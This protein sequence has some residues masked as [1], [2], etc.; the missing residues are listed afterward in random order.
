MKIIRRYLNDILLIKSKKKNDLRGSFLKIF[1]KKI[2]KSKNINFEIKDCFISN[3]KKNVIRGMHYDVLK[4]NNNK[5][6]ICTKGEVLDVILDIRKNSNTYGKFCKIK[7]NE[8]DDKMIFI[9]SG[10]AH[11]FQSL[12]NGSELLYFSSKDYV[13][14]DE[15][16]F[17]WNSFGFNWPIKKPILSKRDTLHPK[18]I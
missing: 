13:K 15:R 10:F 7:I 16:G 6:I 17:L 12:K 2:L 4:K 5:L 3:S 1:N 8:N 9:P 18:F 14:L 11:G